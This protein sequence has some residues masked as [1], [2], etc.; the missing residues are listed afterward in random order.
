MNG[1]CDSYCK[2]ASFL[3]DTEKVLLLL[4]CQQSGVLVPTLFIM[5]SL[6]Y[7]AVFVVFGIFTGPAPIC[8]N[9]H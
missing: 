2:V 8:H 7:D 4:E 9:S 3:S 1:L 6:H 5:D